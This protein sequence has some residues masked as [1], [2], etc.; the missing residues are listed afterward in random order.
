[1]ITDMAAEQHLE[2]ANRILLEAERRRDKAILICREL[3]ELGAAPDELD[4]AKEELYAAASAVGVA[5]KE[6]RIWSQTVATIE[7]HRQG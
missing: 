4:A 6:Q 5:A 3:S 2:E 1:M 7:R